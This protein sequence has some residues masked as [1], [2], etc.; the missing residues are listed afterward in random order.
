MAEDWAKTIAKKVE[1]RVAEEADKA[2]ALKKRFEDGVE[3]FRKQVLDLVA[4][5]NANIATEANRIQTIVLDHG[6]ILSSA[7]KRLVTFE[8]M[9]VSAGIPAC[10]G[11]VVIHRENRKA[12]TP[13]EPEEIYLT[14]AGVQTAFYHYIGKDLKI[15]SDVEFRQI[16]EYFAS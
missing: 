6:I 5:V 4:A 15:M 13:P 1:G 9:G 11:K 10:V 3:R 7:Y 14:S 8:E 12:A 16:V 2:A